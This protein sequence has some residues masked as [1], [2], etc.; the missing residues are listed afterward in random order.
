MDIATLELVPIYIYKELMGTATSNQWNKV[1]IWV[2]DLGSYHIK[3]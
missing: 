1:A 2:Y 3:S